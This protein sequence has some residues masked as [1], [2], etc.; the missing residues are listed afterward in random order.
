MANQRNVVFILALMAAVLM[1]TATYHHLNVNGLDPRL[2]L[3]LRTSRA[4]PRYI[5]VDLGANRGDSLDVFLGNKDGK[6]QYSFPCPGWATPSQAGEY[7]K[8]S[9]RH[10]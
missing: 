1:L 5:F 8:E 9:R 3:G 4:K 10:I 2:S 6:F 7:H